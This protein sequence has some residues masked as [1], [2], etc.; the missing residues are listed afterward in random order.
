[1]KIR[2]T[3]LLQL[4]NVGQG[5]SLAEVISNSKGLCPFESPSSDFKNGENEGQP[6]ITKGLCP[7]ESP[8]T[9][10]AET[11]E[12]ANPF[13]PL[14]LLALRFKGG[15][16]E[17]YTSPPSADSVD[18]SSIPLIPKGLPYKCSKCQGKISAHSMIFA[19]S[20]MPLSYLTR[21]VNTGF[22]GLR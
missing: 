10:T 20:L 19:H 12:K 22:D 3:L 18:S 5:K 2:I 4:I 8:K 14:S 17:G 15:E 9:K 1:M 11:A 16:N 21:I 6:L 7:F 13:S